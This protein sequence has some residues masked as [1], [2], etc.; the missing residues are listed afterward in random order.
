MKTQTTTHNMTETSKLLNAALWLVQ[1][2][3]AVMLLMSG[4]NKIAGNEQMVGLFN[5]IG[6]GHWFRYFT[7]LLEVG[8]SVLL[9]IPAL[10]GVG[11]VILAGVMVG[12]VATHLFIIGGSPATAI[13]LLVASA[14]IAWG[15][16]EKTLSLIRKN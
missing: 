12:A 15:R 14:F 11:G 3:T 1:I 5:V 4:Y 7:G 13:T 16:K 8:G 9:F 2:G 6:I 10:S